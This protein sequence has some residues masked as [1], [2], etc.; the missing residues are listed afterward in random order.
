MPVDGGSVG[1]PTDLAVAFLEFSING[2]P[3]ERIHLL[4]SRQTNDLD[5]AVRVSRW[6]EGA[7]S[8]QLSPVSIEPE[9]TFDLPVFEFGRPCGDPPF[10]LRQR[11]RMVL[12]APQSF[13]ARPY[14][15]I[16]AAEFNPAGSE[17]PIIVAGQRALRLDSTDVTRNPITGYPGVDRKILELRE[18]LRLEPRISET[19]IRDALIL[20]APLGNLMGRAVQDA[21]YPEPLLESLFQKDV[22]QRLRQSPEISVELEE[23]PNSTGGRADLSFRGIRIEL[24]S[25]RERRLSPKDCKQYAEQA[26]S[27]GV[28]T[29]RRLALLCV[30]DSSVK[31]DPPI[32]VEDGLFVIPVQTA[33]APVYVVTCL[34]QGGL[35]K[36]SS[37]PRYPR[38]SLIGTCR[39]RGASAA[40]EPMDVSFASDEFSS[41]RHGHGLTSRHLRRSE[42]R[43]RPNCSLQWETGGGGDRL[44]P[45]ISS[46]EACGTAQNGY[47]G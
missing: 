20:L 17:Q 7:K 11:G 37:L 45:G 29:N 5:I 15:F 1:K 16:Y 2:R 39:G 4:P 8:L 32:P 36:P 14:E 26:A 35:P 28:G 27:Y 41:S 34:V 38:V 12:H 23:Q 46:R 9:S 25:E 42:R 21:L 24:K 18:H 31:A 44:S 43:S 6:P 33:T 13:H 19:D 22:Q 10:L 30:L 3:A 40:P 47:F